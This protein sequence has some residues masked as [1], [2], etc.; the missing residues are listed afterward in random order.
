MFENEQ[1]FRKVVAGLR[2][3]AEPDPANRERLRR[4]M[5]ERF[6]QARS[7]GLRTED[8][9]QPVEPIRPTFSVLRLPLSRLAV[10]AVVLVAATAAV[11]VWHSAT[12]GPANFTQVRL[13][14]KKMPWLHAVVSMFQNGDV[15]TQQ[16]WYNFAAQQAYVVMDDGAVLGWEYGGEQKKLVYSPRLKALM[17]SELPTTGL[18]GCAS[19]YNLVDAFA[20]LAAG[21]GVDERTTEHEGKRVQAYGLERTDPGF[22]IAGRPVARFGITLMAD[23][24]TKRVVAAN[25]EHRGADGKLLVREE[26]VVT[27]PASGPANIYDAGVP[28]TARVVDMRQGYIG[29]PGNEPAPISTPADTGASKLAP[30]EIELPTA[31]FIGTPQI[32]GV[33]NLEKPRKGPRPPFLAPLG[34]TNVALGKPVTSSDREPLV[35]S[36]DLITDGDKE[37]VDGSFVE[38]GPFPQHVTIDLRERCEVYAIVVWHHHKKPRVYFDVAVQVSNDRTFRTGVTTVFNN[39]TDNSLGLG[40]G[41]DMHYTETNEGK[42]IDCK[43]VRGRYVR[44]HSNGNTYDELNHYIEVEVYGRPVRSIKDD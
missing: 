26:W 40:A 34:T 4:Q 5:L 35:G 2:I 38:L 31:K 8:R 21:D 18:F 9:G 37:V 41:R 27:Y 44:L 24:G 30:L 17:I 20:Q 28:R 32:G 33:P 39:D 36:L 1:E 6:E 25:A 10:A 29:T 42:L 14:T 16:H 3:D 22:M 11:W 43:G 15:R 12:G 23:P 7:R 19:A 13:A